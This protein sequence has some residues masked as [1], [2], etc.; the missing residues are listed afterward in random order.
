MEK[1]L[2]RSMTNRMIS[3]VC[4]GIGDYFNIDPTIVRLIAV[5]LCVFT[6]VAPCVIAYIVATIVMPEA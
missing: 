1:K 2:Y 5:A 6:A 4:G 3:G